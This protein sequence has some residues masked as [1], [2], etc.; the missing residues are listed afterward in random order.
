MPGYA[1]LGM[2][3]VLPFTALPLQN[4]GPLQMVIRLADNGIHWRWD[5]KG[6]Q[7]EPFLQVTHFIPINFNFEPLIIRHQTRIPCV[8]II[9]NGAGTQPSQPCY[10]MRDLCGPS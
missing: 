7:V 10:M 2:R 9:S 6:F 4:C 1:Q 5:C 8:Y 3:S